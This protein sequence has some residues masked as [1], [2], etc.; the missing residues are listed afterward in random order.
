M[1][2]EE[3]VLMDSLGDAFEKFKELDEVHPSDRQEFA[4]HIHALQNIVLSREGLT[5]Y[6]RI[7]QNQYQP[8]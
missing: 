7:K 2:S 1:S 3:I 4:F 8:E 5:E 6:R